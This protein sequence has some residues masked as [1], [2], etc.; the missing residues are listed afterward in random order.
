MIHLF[1]NGIFLFIFITLRGYRLTRKYHSTIMY[2]I[3]VNLFY[4]VICRNYLMWN[5]ENQKDMYEF[6]IE[7]LYAFIGLPISTFLFLYYCPQIK[8]RLK[9]FFHFLKWE[10]GYILVEGIMVRSEF[11]Q[12]DN[13]WNFMW[14]ILFVFVMFPVLYIHHKKTS[15]AY[16]ISVVFI[17]FLLWYFKVPILSSIKERC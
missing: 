11:I 4:L 6:L 15:L 7:M 14:S 2:I 10:A 5:Y 17:C 9:F 12:Y 16:A 3:L 13:G 1:I 8:N